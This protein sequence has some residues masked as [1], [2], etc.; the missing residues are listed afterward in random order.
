MSVRSLNINIYMVNLWK[1][2]IERGAKGQEV[3]INMRTDS[4]GNLDI[5]TNY[6]EMWPLV[7]MIHWHGPKC[8]RVRESLTFRTHGL[9]KGWGILLRGPLIFILFLYSD[10]LKKKE[11]F[12]ECKLKFYFFNNLL[13]K[14]VQ[15]YGCHS[16]NPPHPFPNMDSNK[17]FQCCY[18]K[19]VLLRIFFIFQVKIQQFGIHNSLFGSR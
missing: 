19:K 7:F 3:T 4:F 8:P 1:F 15:Q 14:W 10:G 6:M 18:S 12:Q 5:N 16:N 13:C 9:P 17:C 11:I 2:W